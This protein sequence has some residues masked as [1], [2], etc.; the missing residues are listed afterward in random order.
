MSAWM[1]YGAGHAVGMSQGVGRGNLVTSN[2][3]V[4]TPGRGFT[5]TVMIADYQYSM[6]NHLKVF[7]NTR[8]CF[9]FLFYFSMIVNKNVTEIE[10]NVLLRI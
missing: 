10:N 9:F 2:P 8:K 1:S 4:S 6:Q 5:S 3:L 7:R